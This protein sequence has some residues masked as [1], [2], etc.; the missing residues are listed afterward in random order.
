[1]LSSFGSGPNLII[2]ESFFSADIS[3]LN[4]PPSH[5]AGQAALFG[6][7][8]KWEG[9]V[10]CTMCGDAEWIIMKAHLDDIL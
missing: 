8:G 9:S 5:R 4:F 7:L 10:A 2:L 3:A 6:G 1:M